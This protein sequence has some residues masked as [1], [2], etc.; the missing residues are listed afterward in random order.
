MEAQG[1]GTKITMTDHGIQVE[2]T[3]KVGSQAVIEIP[4]E[5]IASVRWRPASLFSRG[6]MQFTTAGSPAGILSVPEFQ[7]G[8]IIFKKSQQ[9]GMEQ[10]K[11]AVQEKINALRRST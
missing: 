1:V 10:I 2:P 9:A 6:W 5:Q 4:F 7:P 8:S 3:W 11:N